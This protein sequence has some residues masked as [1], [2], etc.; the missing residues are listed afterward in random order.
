VCN[1]K[2][3]FAAKIVIDKNKIVKNELILHSKNEEMY[4]LLHTSNTRIIFYL[5]SY[6][7]FKKSQERIIKF[8]SIDNI[9]PIFYLLLYFVIFVSL[10]GEESFFFGVSLIESWGN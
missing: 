2:Q 3:H 8:H 4:F 7:K 6:V 5:C 1:I 9:I 10:H